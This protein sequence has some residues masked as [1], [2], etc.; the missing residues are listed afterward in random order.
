M[1]KQHDQKD[2]GCDCKNCRLLILHMMLGDINNKQQSVD[3][4][5]S[6]QTSD[7]KKC[8]DKNLCRHGDDED[9]CQR[10]LVSGLFQ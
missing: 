2:L 7:N 1:N 10:C 6:Q 4:N 8:H 5:N 9:L 3:I